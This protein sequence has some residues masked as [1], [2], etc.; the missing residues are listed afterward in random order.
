MKTSTITASLLLAGLLAASGSAFAAGDPHDSYN[1][2]FF[3]KPLQTQMDT[4]GKAAYGQPVASTTADGHAA[5]NRALLGVTAQPQ[6]DE[7]AMGKAAWGSSTS[8]DGNAIY[9][10]A[11]I[12]N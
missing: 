5:Y 8:V 12:G 1:H 4:M 3:G 10:K 6:P 9:H 2:A 7:M 11:L